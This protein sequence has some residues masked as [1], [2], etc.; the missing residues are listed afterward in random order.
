MGFYRTSAGSLLSSRNNSFQWIGTWWKDSYFERNHGGLY[1]LG[2]GC[3]DITLHAHSLCPACLFHSLQH[4]FPPHHSPRASS[5]RHWWDFW[6]L[7]EA[8]ACGNPVIVNRDPVQSSPRVAEGKHCLMYSTISLFVLCL[9]K[10]TIVYEGHEDCSS[11]GPCRT[12]PWSCAYIFTFIP[13]GTMPWSK[14]WAF[15]WARRL[16]GLR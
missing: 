8:A 10:D 7:K 6:G 5:R 11:H 16:R 15:Y 12:S 2:D 3:G 9:V 14:I 1:F 13:S 4:G